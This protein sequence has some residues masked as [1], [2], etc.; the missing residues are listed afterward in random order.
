VAERVVV[1]LDWQNV[2][3]RARAAFGLEA[4][5]H[6]AG[7]VNP[8]GLARLLTSRVP[9]GQLHQV[10]IYRGI[11]TNKANPKGYAA[12]RRQ[13]AHWMR[14]SPKPYVYIRPLQYLPGYDPREKGIDVQIAIDFTVM[15]V[16]GEYDVGVLFSI[17]TDLKPALD[18][19]CDLAPRAKSGT[20]RVEV[21]A[22]SGTF[23][24]P[25]RITPTGSHRV[26]CHWL[27]D[28]DFAAVRDDTDYGRP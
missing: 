13:V 9:D 19:V 8:V 12:N 17:D 26:K 16:K 15:A 6:M 20:V 22:W 14:E 2:Y 11:P 10:R 21:A 3:R 24:Q 1:F 25:R 28:R 18:A 4:D 7:Q 5:A 23:A 27:D